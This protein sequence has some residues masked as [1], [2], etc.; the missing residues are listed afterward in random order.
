MKERETG[1]KGENKEEGGGARILNL[2]TRT[3][4]I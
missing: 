2:T 1:R 3:E 4:T